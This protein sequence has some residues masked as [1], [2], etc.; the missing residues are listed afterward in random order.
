MKIV[1]KAWKVWADNDEFN[2]Y[3]YYGNTEEL[4]TV[5]ADSAG[6]AK[7]KCE[8]SYD[9]FTE[10]KCKRHKDAD[11]VMF[12]G[13]EMRYSSANQITADRKKRAERTEK[14]LQFPEEA[15]FYVQNATQCYIGNSVYLWAKNGSGY[16]INPDKAH[17]YTR[18]E[19]ITDFIQNDSD[20]TF[21]EAN[22]FES[23]ISKHVDGQ[24][25]DFAFNVR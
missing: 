18:Q 14:I 17:K 16:T 15:L 1:K 23:K 22:H 25:L 8:F 11:I 20:A 5:Y 12:E 6:L 7:K 24:H 2:E 4:P 10:I 9:H 19:I 21:W 3:P 13:R